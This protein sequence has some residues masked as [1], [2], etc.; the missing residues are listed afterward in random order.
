MMEQMIITVTTELLSIQN[1]RIE[2]L[3]KRVLKK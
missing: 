1:K 2:N 3:S